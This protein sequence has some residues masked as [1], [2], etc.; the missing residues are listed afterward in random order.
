MDQLQ[1]VRSE[2]E[3]SS[4]EWVGAWYAAPMRMQP[5]HLEGRTL[6]QIVH[7]HAGGKQIRLRLSTGAGH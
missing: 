5:A 6:Y 1:P 3:A 2:R 7:L 4:P